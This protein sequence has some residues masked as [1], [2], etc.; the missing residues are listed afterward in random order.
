MSDEQ[1][2]GLQYG[3]LPNKQNLATGSVVFPPIKRTCIV[4][5]R[6]L[7]PYYSKPLD[8]RGRCENR[9]CQDV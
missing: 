6:L 3:I 5:G 9:K 7:A 4:C 1:G 2:K 8:E